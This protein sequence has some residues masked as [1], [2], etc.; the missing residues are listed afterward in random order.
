MHLNKLVTDIRQ[1]KDD[2]SSEKWDI[3]V[4]VLCVPVTLALIVLILVQPPTSNWIWVPAENAFMMPIEAPMQIE[5]PTAADYHAATKNNNAGMT[6]AT[7]A[8][9]STSCHASNDPA[10]CAN[11]SQPEDAQRS[12]ARQGEILQ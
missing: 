7:T 5:Q 2:S 1:K 8:T 4:L 9:G 12:F 11:G 10:V 3:G 6:L